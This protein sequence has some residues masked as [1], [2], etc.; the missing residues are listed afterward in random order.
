MKSSVQTLQECLD[1]DG[2]DLGSSCGGCVANFCN[3]SDWGQG[4]YGT[5]VSSLIKNSVRIKESFLPL[6]VTPIML[7]GWV[8]TE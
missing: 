3:P 5:L 7:I 6:A 8:G 1:I 4:R 2:E